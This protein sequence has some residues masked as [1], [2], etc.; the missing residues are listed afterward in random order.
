MIRSRIESDLGQK[1]IRYSA[2]SVISVAAGQLSLI[3][4]FYFGHWSARPANVLSCIVGG[5]PSFF[6]NRRW[7]WGKKGDHRVLAEM[8]PFWVMSFAGLALS[9]WLAGFAGTYGQDH[10]DSRAIQTLLV[11]GASLV[12]FG[13]L[14]V[15]KFFVLDRWLFTTD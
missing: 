2:V 14:W 13:G 1:L 5:I 9:T 3:A 7:S 6:L 4:A 10:F 8:T 11:M 12:S 15:L